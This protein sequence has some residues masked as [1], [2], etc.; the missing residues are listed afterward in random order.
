MEIMRILVLTATYLPTINGVSVYINQHKREMEKLGHRVLIVAP[1]HP[2]QKPE[3]GVIRMPSIHNPLSPDY[4]LVIP[5]LNNL[6]QKVITSFE[7]QIIIFH[8]P[9][10]IS[11]LAYKLSNQFNIPKIFIYHTRYDL[12]LSHY[13]PKFLISKVFLNPVRKSVSQSDLVIAETPTLEKSLHAQYPKARIQLLVTGLP[14]M[15]YIKKTK[16]ELRAIYHLPPAGTILLN[17][18]RLAAE[19]N[20]ETLVKIYSQIENLDQTHLVLIG[21]GPQKNYLVTLTNSLKLAQHVT[22]LGSFSPDL[23]P[24]IY[25]LADIYVYTSLTETQGFTILEAMSAGLPIVALKAPGPQDFVTQ[26]KNGFLAKNETEMVNYLKILLSDRNLQKK[27]SKSA[28]SAASQFTISSWS[29]SWDQLLKS[30]SLSYS[31]I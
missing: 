13:L 15:A 1:H 9:Y 29:N 4:P 5:Y 21:D 12:Y 27:L 31:R 3:S 25:S 16:K 6:N 7:P 11:N 20:L 17:V 23:M 24:Q 26:N 19:K 28:I 30:S 10:V 14:S 2:H 22:F 8:H 18:G